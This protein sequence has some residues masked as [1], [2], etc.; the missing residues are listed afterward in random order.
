MYISVPCGRDGL[1]SAVIAGLAG[2]A[3]SAYLHRPDPTRLLA[4]FGAQLSAMGET[5]ER[6]DAFNRDRLCQVHAVKLEGF[7]RRLSILEAAE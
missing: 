2:H 4:V 5:V 7:D 1:S 6:I 3:L